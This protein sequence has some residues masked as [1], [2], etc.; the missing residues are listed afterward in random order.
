LKT[1]LS[2]PQNSR[3]PPGG[4]LRADKTIRADRVNNLMSSMT[5]KKREN[6]SKHE[7]ARFKNT[8]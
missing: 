2:H 3:L 6:T 1:A 5:K 8:F 4:C 7:E